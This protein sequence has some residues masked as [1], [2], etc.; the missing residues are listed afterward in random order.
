MIQFNG[1]ENLGYTVMLDKQLAYN[2]KGKYMFIVY[3]NESNNQYSLYTTINKDENA[4][5][6]D[7]LLEQ[8]NQLEEISYI[9]YTDQRLIAGIKNNDD[10][11]ALYIDRLVNQLSEEL[12][13]QGYHPYCVYA[14]RYED[15]LQVVSY[16]GQ[17]ILMS[18]NCFEDLASKYKPTNKTSVGKGILGGFIGSLIGVAAWIIIYQFGYIAGITGFVMALCVFKGYE[19]LGGRLDK[20]SVWICIGI[21][22]LMLL[23][24]ELI[25]LVLEIY[26]EFSVYYAISMLDAF[27]ALPYFLAD[28]EI[29]AVI[30]E[31]MV[32]GYV[33]MA[34][35]SFS[36]IR[37]IHAQAVKEDE[38]E[39]LS[40]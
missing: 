24:A 2:K 13:Q 25:C 21:S 14:H 38:I 10:I 40:Q 29:L 1:L 17:C 9:R 12:T 4:Q 8:L 22:V 37:T 23:V 36:Y 39:K 5:S 32:M 15:H 31:E 26:N 35:S 28:R 16:N 6:I 20:K 33:F 7:T 11:N 27:L 19:F 30:V 3:Y 18:E 34:L